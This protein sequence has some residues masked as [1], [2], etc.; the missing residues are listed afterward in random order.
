MNLVA[1]SSAKHS[2]RWSGSFATQMSASRIGR[3]DRRAECLLCRRSDITE[4]RWPVRFVSLPDPRATAN[5]QQ[6]GE[7]KAL[8]LLRR[9]SLPTSGNSQSSIGDIAAERSDDRHE[10]TKQIYGPRRVEPHVQHSQEGSKCGSY[11]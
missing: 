4:A 8:T 7:R 11:C 9:R 10:N 2:P 5:L 6:T 3:F 1:P